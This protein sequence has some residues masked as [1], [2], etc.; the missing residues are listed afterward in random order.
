[1]ILITFRSSLRII[2]AMKFATCLILSVILG[3]ALSSPI[4]NVDNM[5]FPETPISKLPFNSFFP[6]PEL[7]G[8]I[9]IMNNDDMFYWLFP[10]RND[11]DKDP[12]VIWLS[13]GPG[14]SS[15][16]AIF[17]EN[18]PLSIK[19]GEAVTDD[20]S[21]NN[22]ANLVFVDQPIGTGFSG[23]T[24]EDMPKFEKEVARQFEIFL[25]GFY[26]KY[27]AFKN[28]DLYITGESYA[29]H[30]IPFISAKILDSQDSTDAGIK[31]AG[32]GI[33]NGWVAPA[34]QVMGYAPFAYQNRL[35]NVI[36]NAALQ[37]GFRFCRILMEY[38]IPY[39]NLVVCNYLTQSVLGSPLSP[40]F[41]VYDIRRKCDVPPLCYD[42]SDLETYL[43]RQDVQEALG[44]AGRKWE[45]CNMEVHTAMLMDWGTNAAPNVAK[46][47]K[48]GLK[49]LIYNGDKDY[50][51]NWM[52]GEIWVKEMEWDHQ[53]EFNSLDYQDIGYAKSLKLG[54][55]E[56]LRFLNAGHMVPMDQP[57]NA[58]KML[59]RLVYDWQP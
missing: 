7:H 53:E 12:L 36:G 8:L 27:P 19:K 2:N 29:G 10:S 54:N 44:V 33:G 41:N 34:S 37:T 23:G 28:R 48:A 18:G 57:E 45:S 43:N 55:F 17:H 13:G 30:Y 20:I 50:I 1:M 58:L 25:I 21:W 15:T 35:I 32:V 59:D 16:L 11:P 47:I 38:N 9:P 39:F 4:L 52:G 14:C 40:R 5:N 6:E 42:F 46:L 24:L 51:C 3:C 22:R 26:E 31:L 56:F 49:V